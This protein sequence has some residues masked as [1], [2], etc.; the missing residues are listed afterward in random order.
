MGGGT[1]QT[2]ERLG[3]DR[4]VFEPGQNRRAW[5]GPVSFGLYGHLYVISRLMWEML[6][7]CRDWEGKP[8]ACAHSFLPKQQKKKEKNSCIQSQKHMYRL[9]SQLVRH[10]WGHPRQQYNY[11][12]TLIVSANNFKHKLS[13]C[14]LWAYFDLFRF[15]LYYRAL[16]KHFLP[17]KIT[18]FYFF[19]S[20]YIILRACPVV[21]FL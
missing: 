4:A 20:F 11:S 17:A 10:R 7:Q 13:M 18:F 2:R 6:R 15:L 12:P 3:P 14:L 1:A 8:R 21:N 5:A 9:L 19:L 16:L